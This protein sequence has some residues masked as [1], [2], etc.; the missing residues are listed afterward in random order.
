MTA[1]GDWRA[2]AACGGSRSFAAAKPTEAKEICGGCPVR[3]ECLYD[4]LEADTSNGIWG[5]LTY[6][7]RRALPALPSGRSAALDKL[8]QLLAHTDTAAAETVAPP[9]ADKPRRETPQAVPAMSRTDTAAAPSPEDS[10]TER[11]GSAAVAG[12]EDVA[13]LLRQGATQRQITK[14]LGV[15]ARVVTATRRA[16][17]IPYPKGPGFRYTPEQ[18]AENERRTLELLRAGA[19]F[20]QII[21]QVGISAPTIIRI[22]REAGLGP[23][24]QTGG[25][26]SRSVADVLAEHVEPYGDGH[27]RWSGPM[28]GRMPQLYA[29]GGRCNARHAVFEQH[30]GRPPVGYVRSDCREQACIAGA[31]LTDDV[32]RR[33]QPEEGPVTVQALKDLLTEIDHQGGPQAARDNRLHLTDQEPATMT[34]TSKPTTPA[35][36]A[37]ASSLAPSIAQSTAEITAEA[38]PIGSLLKWGDEHPDSDVQDQAAR[39]RALL[40]AL[41]NRH[42]ADQELTAITTEAEQLEKRLA[43][44]RSREAELAPKKKRKSS[45]YVRDYD[46]REVRAWA[47]AN[48]IDCPRV[49]QVPKRVLD[50]WRAATSAPDGQS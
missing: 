6:G 39:A 25:H 47:A 19:T 41:R 26:P 3:V 8:R 14:E 12:R 45:T 20:S 43:E 16:Y 5:G 21:E 36:P 33:A 22:R 35:A 4:A 50:A 1:D 9:A 46:T 10:G 44:L 24:G 49:G 38:L 15:S 13:E 17:G 37:P 30:H 28:S 48:G 40:T 7:E 2:S 29:D 11:T 31:H 32:L 27:A 23:S 42:A 34:T 18:R